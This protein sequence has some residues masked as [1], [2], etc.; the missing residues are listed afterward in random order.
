MR[1]FRP[2]PDAAP[3]VK[4]WQRCVS[5]YRL[6]PAQSWSAD[7][8]SGAEFRTVCARSALLLRAATPETQHLFDLSGGLGLMVVLSDRDATVLARRMNE[9]HV[10]VCRRIHLQE[11]AI[12][13]ETA[14]GTNGVG[15]ALAD[16][17]AVSINP[18]D[19]WRYC[20]SLIAS[21]AAPIFDAHGAVTGALAL[22][23]PQGQVNRAMAPLLIDTITHSC[24]RIEENLFRLCHPKSRIMTLGLAEG[25]SAPLVSVN[26]DGQVTG[27]THAARD[28]LG[29]TD[30]T[31]GNRPN[32]F[33]A[34]E[35]SDAL[36]FRRAEE[37]VVQAALAATKG[38]ISAAARNLGIS[39]ATLYR[40][41]RASGLQ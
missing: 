41:M 6:D 36:S 1:D 35:S 5:S 23:A 11:G 4:S 9:S 7:V 34:L 21:Y 38:N 27:A 17:E 37:S 10:P 29:W 15:T 8:M 31:I 14:A 33:S 40:K 16:R 24:R 22:S 30:E 26:E 28:L 18:G 12:W 13:C 19:H 3:I 25:C 39:R 2:A 32:L 20:L